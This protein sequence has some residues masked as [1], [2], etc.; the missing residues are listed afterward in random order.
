MVP[1]ALIFSLRLLAIY[2]HWL[3]V[4]KL[5]LHTRTTFLATLAL[6]HLQAECV[7]PQVMAK[8]TFAISMS[9]VMSV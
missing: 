7:L 5:A 6:K 4:D 8:Q 2:C 3:E 9:H 1:T